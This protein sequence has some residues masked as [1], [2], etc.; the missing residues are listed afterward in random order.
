MTDNNILITDEIN[1]FV[2]QN[3]PWVF[4]ENTL[5]ASFEFADVVDAMR[6]VNLVAGEAEQMQHHPFWSNEYN[7]LA[8]VLSTHDAGDVVTKK[9]L[10][11]AMAISK[12]IKG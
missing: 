11:L 8:F 7:R 1:E 6:V 2:S 12:I 3:P 4:R 9:D 5:E 10:D